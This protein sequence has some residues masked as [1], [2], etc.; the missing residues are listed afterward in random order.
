MKAS[1]AMICALAL[2]LS[3]QPA[4]AAFEACDTQDVFD[5]RMC[6]S[7]MCTK[8]SFE[9]CMETCQKLQEKHSGCRCSDWPE[10]RLSYSGGEFEGKGKF[11][12]VGDYSKD[13]VGN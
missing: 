2:L 12:D 7:F 5:V 4:A 1:A 10:A 11:G 6:K 3:A 8:C 13:A 9:W